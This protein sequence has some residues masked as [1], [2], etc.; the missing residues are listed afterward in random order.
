MLQREFGAHV[1]LSDAK[2]GDWLARSGHSLDEPLAVLRV[3]YIKGL[4]LVAAGRG[5]QEGQAA[6]MEAKRLDLEAS[7]RLKELQFFEKTGELVPAADFEERIEAVF[8]A[9]RNELDSF[10]ERAAAV[11]EKSL[12]VSVDADIFEPIVVDTLSHLAGNAQDDGQ[13][14]AA[15]LVDVQAA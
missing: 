8:L 12:R 4:R 2:V 7:T 1:H 10:P 3:A 15:D 9:V 5:G 6:M 14:G 11:A 13:D